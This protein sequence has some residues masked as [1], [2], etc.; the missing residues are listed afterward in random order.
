MTTKP[1]TG[2]PVIEVKDVT[3]RFRYFADRPTSL[4]TVLTNILRFKFD[5]GQKQEFYSLRNVSFDIYPGEFVGI[6]G[7]NGAGKSTLLKLISGIYHP[8]L[9]EIRTHGQIA[10]L[11]ELGAGFHPDL[12]GYENVFLNAAILGAGKKAAEAALPSILDFSELAEKIYMPVKNYSSGMLVRL[13]FSIAVHFPA[14]I[15]LVDEILAVGDAGFQAKC[16]KKIESLHQ[17]G[18]TIVLITHDPAA[19]EAHCSR[20]IV[21]EK[22][23]KVYDGPVAEGT[24]IYRNLFATI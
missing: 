18:R 16:L 23:E 2:V 8:T 5:F 3:K 15:L 20:C 4:K 10:P 13:A 21:I 12:S 22:Q 14:P 6:M 24:A 1:V 17:E 19:I 7:R 9:G 11:I